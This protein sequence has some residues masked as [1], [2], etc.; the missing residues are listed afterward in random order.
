MGLTQCAKCVI[1]C[2]ERTVLFVRLM[3]HTGDR[4]QRGWGRRRPPAAPLVCDSI[5]RLRPYAPASGSMG[6]ME[7]HNGPK[8]LWDPSNHVNTSGIKTNLITCSSSLQIPWPIIC[9]THQVSAQLTYLMQPFCIVFKGLHVNSKCWTESVS[10]P[11]S[12]YVF[13][14]MYT[15]T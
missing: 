12:L 6:F 4:S 1:E 8:A 10:L 11:R 5:P 9:S 14:Y 2:R 15:Y 7:S 13:A 3:K